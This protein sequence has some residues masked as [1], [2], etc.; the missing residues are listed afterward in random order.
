LPEDAVRCSATSAAVSAV[1]GSGD[2]APRLAASMEESQRDC[3]G[4]SGLAIR[5][6]KRPTKTQANEAPIKM[7]PL[8]PGR[9]W[10]NVPAATTTGTPAIATAKM[11]RKARVTLV[12]SAVVAAQAASAAATHMAVGK[13]RSGGASDNDAP[14]TATSSVV[15]DSAKALDARSPTPS[16]TRLRL[17]RR[18]LAA[19]CT[20][21]EPVAALVVA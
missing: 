1:S 16:S 13:K 11:P 14:S 15:T 20:S 12:G 4:P 5:C 19:H 18:K 8:A 2:S 21:S 6:A 10:A 17:R 3:S 9:A 7:L